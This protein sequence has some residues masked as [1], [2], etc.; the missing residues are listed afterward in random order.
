LSRLSPGDLGDFVLKHPDVPTMQ[1]EEVRRL[2]K[3]RLGLLLDAGA[4]PDQGVKTEETGG[5]TDA[6]P[7][8][9]WRWARQYLR[10]WATVVDARPEAMTAA[11]YAEIREVALRVADTADE[12]ALAAHHVTPPT[13]EQYDVR[14]ARAQAALA[15]AESAG[16]T[17]S[18][19]PTGSAGVSPAPLQFAAG[20]TPALRPAVNG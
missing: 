2:V 13:R 1:R 12:G 3:L 15:A 17:G 14:L 9:L 7:Q 18:A 8:T 4:E 16:R 19:V 5:K 6:S 10:E 11:E 20:G